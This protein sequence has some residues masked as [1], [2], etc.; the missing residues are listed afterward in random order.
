[1]KT[2][3][4]LMSRELVQVDPGATVAE[5]AS[6]MSQRSVGSVLVMDGGRLAGIFTE[7][8]I[9][10]A[11]SHDIHAPHEQVGD[12]MSRQPSTISPEASGGE[13][14]R[15]MSEGN[16]RH[17]PVVDAAGGL[18]GMLSMRDL[19]RAGVLADSKRG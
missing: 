4:E 6:I 10:R 2:V 8:D 15:R 1:M 12:W 16:F 7:R 5:V 18:V 13:A 17:L 9:V 14:A 19:V 11:I 3:A